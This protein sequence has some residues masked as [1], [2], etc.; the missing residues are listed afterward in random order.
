MN[1]QNSLSFARQQDRTDPLKGFRSKFHLPYINGNQAIYFTGNSLGLLP[2]STKKYIDEE[3]QDWKTLGVEGHLHSRRPWLYYHKFTK[4][5]LA[6]I[7]GAKPS[8]VV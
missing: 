3:L 4:K 7:V 2:K 5:A 1:Y 6:G 8:E